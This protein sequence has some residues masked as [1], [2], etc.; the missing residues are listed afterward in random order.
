MNGEGTRTE[1]KDLAS[2]FFFET[3]VQELLV[4]EVEELFPGSSAGQ[5]FFAP[6]IHEVLR[7]YLGLSG[8]EKRQHTMDPV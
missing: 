2:G 5:E 4:Q 8:A 3:G 6:V 7:K 1:C